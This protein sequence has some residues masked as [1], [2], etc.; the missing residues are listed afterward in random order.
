MLNQSI[1]PE[2]E[3]KRMK[4]EASKMKQ[5]LNDVTIFIPRSDSQSPLKSIFQGLASQAI[6]A[7]IRELSSRGPICTNVN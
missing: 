7:V 2:R 5:N 1:K 4:I 6:Q 3:I